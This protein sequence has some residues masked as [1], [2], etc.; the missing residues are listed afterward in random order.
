MKKLLFI[1]LLYSLHGYTQKIFEVYNFSTQT[2]QIVDIV[3]NASGTYPE[4]HSKS[5]AII[6]LAPG[7]SYILQNTSNP[8]R[9]PF[10]SPTS[11]PYIANWERLDSPTSSTVMTSFNAWLIGSNQDFD[12]MLFALGGTGYSIGTT[13]PSLT[14]SG[15]NAIYQP[16]S[17]PTTY[18]IVFFP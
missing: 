2:V 18:T 16:S 7:D 11:S 6:T 13:N 12:R 10:D 4:F 14:G 3:T 8:F 15:W 9:F 1:L 5:F 17:N